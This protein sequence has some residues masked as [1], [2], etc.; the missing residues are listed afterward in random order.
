M[1]ADHKYAF[2]Y[3]NRPRE[4]V[5]SHMP[6][7]DSAI[8]E[9][10][11]RGFTPERVCLKYSFERLK[12]AVDLED[13]SS[14]VIDRIVYCTSTFLLVDTRVVTRFTPLSSLPSTSRSVSADGVSTDTNTNTK[15]HF[16]WLNRH[17]KLAHGMTPSI[18]ARGDALTVPV[19]G[20]TSMSTKI[21]SSAS[22]PTTFAASNDDGRSPPNTS[23]NR[24]VIA[25]SVIMA[26]AMIIVV[27]WYLRERRGERSLE[28]ERRIRLVQSPRSVLP[29]QTSFHT[30]RKSSFGF[31]GASPDSPWSRIE[32]CGNHH[33]HVGGWREL[34]SSKDTIT[35]LTRAAGQEDLFSPLSGNGMGPSPQQGQ[36]SHT[37]SLPLPPV[38]A[39]TQRTFR[40]SIHSVIVNRDVRLSISARSRGEGM[41]TLLPVSDDQP[42]LARERLLPS[43]AFGQ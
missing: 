41:L 7:K 36:C 37:S 3:A 14:C 12:G 27:G 29:L 33:P 4:D 35:P 31:T 26:V 38:T 28:R 23:L 15:T 18:S 1:L 19:A 5:H 8:G 22:P 21:K 34:I 10:M 9:K 43:F 16:G 6:D 42:C 2:E 24:A 20:E 30:S 13:T 11:A 39:N 25:V 17:Y 32:V 40:T